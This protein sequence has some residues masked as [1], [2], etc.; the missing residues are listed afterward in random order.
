MVYINNVILTS[1]YSIPKTFHYTVKLNLSTKIMVTIPSC[2]IN[3]GIQNCISNT[4]TIEQLTIT[5]K[6]ICLLWKPFLQ[7]M[8]ESCI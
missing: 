6:I 2:V 7:R 5:Y 1:Q 4:L 3:Y 8:K